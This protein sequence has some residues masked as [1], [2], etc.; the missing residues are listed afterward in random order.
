MSTEVSV[1]TVAAL[2]GSDLWCFPARL[3]ARRCAPRSVCC[4]GSALDDDLVDDGRIDEDVGLGA[5]D[6]IVCA[7]EGEPGRGLEMT[8]SAATCEA[9]GCSA[10]FAVVESN[11]R[12]DTPMEKGVD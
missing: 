12:V 2:V 5:V 8:C 10:S 6:L 7:G 4:G 1:M 9:E 11:R 3:V